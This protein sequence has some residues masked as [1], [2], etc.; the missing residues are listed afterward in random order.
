MDL[1]GISYLQ[2]QREQFDFVASTFSAGIDFTVV[3]KRL[4]N[5]PLC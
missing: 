3:M 4:A 1:I 2:K 5:V